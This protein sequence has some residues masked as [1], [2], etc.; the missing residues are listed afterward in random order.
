MKTSKL[1][2]IVLLSI[3]VAC[4]KE[5]VT[6]DQGGSDANQYMAVNI[7]MPAGASTKA[8]GDYRDG[9]EAESTCSTMPMAT[10][11]PQVPFQR[12]TAP[13]MGTGISH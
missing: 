12:L 6:S 9:S 8:T 7:A 3:A 4:S 11:L 10:I 1:I 5:N 2:S 13:W